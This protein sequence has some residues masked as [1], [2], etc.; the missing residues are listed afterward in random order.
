MGFLALGD[1]RCSRGHLYARATCRSR[2]ALMRALIRATSPGARRTASATSSL[3]R[4]TRA[5][6]SL[7]EL[8][9]LF[10]TNHPLEI[11]FFFYR[12]GE[13]AGT[14]TNGIQTNPT[15]GAMAKALKM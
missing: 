2:A 7:S 6:S 9:Q 10:E 14:A 4:T 12:C 8:Q 5:T 15:T 11:V 13:E 3:R 1:E